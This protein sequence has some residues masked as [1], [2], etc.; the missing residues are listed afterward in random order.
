MNVKVFVLIMVSIFSC[1]AI[2][3]D[4]SYT[5]RIDPMSDKNTSYAETC[6]DRNC[7]VVYKKS[8]VISTNHFLSSNDAI[9]IDY[10][11]DKKPAVSILGSPSA[12]GTAAFIVQGTNRT[13]LIHA[14]KS[15]SKI[16]VRIYDYRGA[17]YTSTFS[18][19]GSTNAINKVDPNL[20]FNADGSRED[21]LYWPSH[22]PP[23]Q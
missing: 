16:T 8:V 11:V 4:W 18:L 17:S 22:L 21:G 1:N 23:R 20:L 13:N 2:A 15:G 6:A 14:L 10:R 3:K 19:R 5:E 12:K 7:I 9:K